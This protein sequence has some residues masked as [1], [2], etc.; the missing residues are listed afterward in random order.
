MGYRLFD[1]GQRDRRR[2]GRGAVLAHSSADRHVVER[3]PSRSLQRGEGPARVTSGDPNEVRTSV[4]GE[5]ELAIESLWGGERP[6][7]HRGDIVITE[8]HEGDENRAR[9]QRRND[10]E[11]GVLGRG[12]DEDDETVFHCR[13]EGVLLRLAEPV[14]LVE[15]EHGMPAV[16]VAFPLGGRDDFADVFDPGCDGRQLDEPSPGSGRDQVGER[17]LAGAGRAPEDRRHGADGAG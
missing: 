17:R 6:L 12:R 15:E 2:L 5:G 10:A 13:Q 8:R 9:Q 1:V 14:D 4:I 11:G 16:E 3:Y 7:D